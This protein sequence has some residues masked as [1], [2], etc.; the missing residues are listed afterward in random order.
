MYLLDTNTL[1]YFFKGMGR[2][3]D[4]LLSV[5]PGE[6]FIPSLTVYEIETGIAK[7][8]HP[9]RLQRNLE[10]FLVMV[11]VLPFG[12]H[13]AKSAARIRAHLSDSIPQIWRASQA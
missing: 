7:S 2:V 4:R 3:S 5:P 10:S 11:S 12:F 6:I 8:K 9:E 1:I 13:E